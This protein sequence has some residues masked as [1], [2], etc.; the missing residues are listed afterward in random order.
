L[1]TACATLKSSIF[2]T[3]SCAYQGF[4]AGTIPAKVRRRYQARDAKIKV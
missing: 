2:S 4:L 1:W 3:S